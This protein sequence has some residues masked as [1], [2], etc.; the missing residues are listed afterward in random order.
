MAGENPESNWLRIAK[1]TARRFNWAWFLDKLS[2]PLLI[3]GLLGACLIMLARREWTIFP[4]APS[5][6]IAAGVLASVALIAWLI[7]RRHFTTQ[8][9]ALV[10]LETAMK[11]NN[12]LTAARH[13]IAPWPKAVTE[14]SDGTSWN[15]PRLLVP[16][17]ATLFLLSLAFLL[18]IS[19]KNDP[20]AA[21]PEE[22]ANRQSLQASID[23]L[24]K[25][26]VI[27]EE[28]LDEIEEKV[29]ELREQPKEEWF[30]HSALEATDSLKEAH[31]QQLKELERDVRKAERALNALQNHS[32]GM[33]PETRERL[34]DEFDQSLEK[35][36]NGA[37]KPNKEL[38]KQLGDID[39]NQLGNLTPEQLDQLRQNMREQ[40]Q[41]MQGAG[42]Q[43]QPGEGEGEGDEWLDEL[44]QEGGQP[45]QG[46]GN[47][48]GQNGPGQNG[49]GQGGIN[50]GPGTAPGVLGQEGEELGIGGL[51]GL[52]S[53]DLSNTLPGDLLE[54]QDG[55]HN[56]DKS[57]VG[58]REGGAVEDLGEGGELIWKIA[59]DLHPNEKKALREFFK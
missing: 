45:G 54:L 31:E 18:P 14:S 23:E 17:L 11:L 5:L 40:A 7:A 50:R 4:W 35:M 49:P 28:Y 46:Q 41:K 1:T 29:K 33:T 32:Q 36:N 42:G 51:E 16:P 12:S 48:P 43:P 59:P 10:R 57:K 13:G 38:L 24:R 15:W 9:T 25:D 21:P 19:A 56:V 47:E 26:E 58:V 22:P 52:E 3:A 8:D 20:N 6:A 27:D 44:M 53:R 34:L 55:E 37:M 39:P 2:L 30:D